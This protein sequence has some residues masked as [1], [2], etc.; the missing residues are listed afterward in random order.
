MSSGAAEATPR[1]LTAASVAQIDKVSLEVHDGLLLIALA[2]GRRLIVA[3]I[4][5]GGES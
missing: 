3:R 4:G 1:E 5:A 2:D